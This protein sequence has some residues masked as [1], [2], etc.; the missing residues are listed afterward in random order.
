[1]AMGRK[2]E[3]YVAKMCCDAAELG[4]N[5]F[6]GQIKLSKLIDAPP[7]DPSSVQCFMKSSLHGHGK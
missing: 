7:R 2:A 1:M 3:Y 6:L 5:F 4:L